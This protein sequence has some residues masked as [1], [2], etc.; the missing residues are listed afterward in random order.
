ML[1]TELDSIKPVSHVVEGAVKTS[2]SE[3]GA[4]PPVALVAQALALERGGPG[5]TVTFS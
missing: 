5:E 1:I 3:G 4:T 2:S